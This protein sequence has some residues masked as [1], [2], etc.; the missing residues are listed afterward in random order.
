[1]KKGGGV[2]EIIFGA[3]GGLDALGDAPLHA[4]GKGTS[5]CN[6][7]GVGSFRDV[8]AGDISPLLGGNGLLLRNLEIILIV[9]VS[10]RL[11]SLRARKDNRARRSGE[12]RR[13]R[14]VPGREVLVAADIVLG[15]IARWDGE[16]SSHDRR[17]EEARG[18]GQEGAFGWVGDGAEEGWVGERR[19]V[20]DGEFGTDG[21]GDL[22]EGEGCAREGRGGEREL[23]V[24]IERKYETNVGNECGDGANVVTNGWPG[25]EWRRLAGRGGH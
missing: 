1:M 23:H 18:G 22:A 15:D 21:V 7:G 12:R 5:S 8:G 13:E 9:R 2:T 16:W 10:K 20:H 14:Y 24:S 17:F 11:R 19:G 25:L 4:D 6:D 3:A